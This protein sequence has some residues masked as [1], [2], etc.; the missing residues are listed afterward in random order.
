[1]R[2]SV[3]KKV[4]ASVLTIALAAAPMSAMASGSG[5]GNNGGNGGCCGGSTDAVV[6]EVSDGTYTTV[7]AI[8]TTSS[9]AGVKTT[10]AGIYLATK[11]DGSIIVTAADTIAAGYGLTN[12]EK[13][14]VKFYNFDSK[15]STAAAAAIENAA[16][17]IGA[18]V[19]PIVNLEIGKMSNGKYSL[20]PMNGPAITAKLGIPGNFKKA[21]KTYAI[22]AVRPGGAVSVIA[23][24]DDNAN[25]I[26]FATTGGQGAYAIVCY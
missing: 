21:G 26:T 23:D 17:S 20:L 25:T 4:L 9:V 15:K 14:F 1:M 18:E 22:I 2:V 19:G 13:P 8:P 24:T 7:E 6:A 12:G 3:M 11:V 16:A 10:C 5:S